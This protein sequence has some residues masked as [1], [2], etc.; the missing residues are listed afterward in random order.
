[1]YK[2]WK[3]FEKRQVIVARNKLLEIVVFPKIL[4]TY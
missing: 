3:Y 2:I 1:M 4:R